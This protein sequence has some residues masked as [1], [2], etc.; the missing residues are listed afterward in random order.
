MVKN[1]KMMVMAMLMLGVAM[2]MLGVVVPLIKKI[3]FFYYF[4]ILNL[5][6]AF[7]FRVFFDTRSSARK[8]YSSKNYL[9]IKYLSSDLCHG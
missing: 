3:L 8:K 5:P 2:L 6:S 4:A 9:S 7:Y 1:N